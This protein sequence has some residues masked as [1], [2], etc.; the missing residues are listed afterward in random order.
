MKPAPAL[1]IK[2]GLLIVATLIILSVTIFLMGKERRFFE[3]KVPF[4]IHF[5]RTIGLREGAQISLTGV[6]VGSVE[7]LTFP[8]NVEENYIVVRVNIV[9]DVAQRIRKDTIAR[10]RTQG[11]L[12]DKFIELSGGSSQSEPLPPGSLISSV[13][14]LD[15]EALLG[16]SGDVVQSF[17][18]VAS[19]LKTILK[20]AE[21]GKSLLGQ[22]VAPEHEKKWI[23]AANN[24]RS[25]SAS[26]KNIL[27]SVE[28]G[29]GVLGQLVQNKEAGQAMVEDLKVGLHQLRMATESL[30]KT[31]QKIEHGEGTL[32]TLIQDPHAGKEILA[33]LRRS[34]SNLET[35]T[36]QLREGGGI[37]QRLIM[38]K[39]YADRILG[40]LDQT[41]RDIAQITGKIDRGEGTIG[42]LV[43]DPQLYQEA[44]DLVGN[45]KGSWL[46]SIYRFFRNL[47]SSREDS[48]T[49]GTPEGTEKQGE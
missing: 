14:P 15:Y 21:E 6:R 36:R 12:G 27:S 34:A 24:L 29:E 32:G 43:N 19:S 11:V 41:T 25:V 3:N 35:V 5:S 22:V 30:Q 38:D 8:P 9:G 16:E 4:E 46:F 49:K 40:H 18:S 42:A 1:Q 33:N 28:K 26:L 47:G 23:D 45:A 2:V 48:A 44:K 20:S 31:A 37:L 17:A 7:S 10:I 13:D 39:P